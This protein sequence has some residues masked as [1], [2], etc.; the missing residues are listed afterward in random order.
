MKPIAITLGEPAGIGPDIFL[1]WLQ[2]HREARQTPTIVIT[3][4]ALLMDR[5]K[6]LSITIPSELVILHVPLKSH[7]CAGFLNLDNATY[8]LE[9][10]QAAAEGCLDGEFAGMVTGPVH[11]AALNEA[12]IPFTGHTEW[13]AKLMG[14]KHTMM[15]FVT[16]QLKIALHTTHIPLA[17]VASHI[18]SESLGRNIRLLS[19]GLNQYFHLA[20][21]KI[22]VCGLNPHA[23]EQGHCGREEIEIIQPLLRKLKKNGFLLTGPLPADTAFIPSIRDTHDVILA[24]YHDQGLPVIKALGFGQAVNVTLGLPIFRAS[25]DHGTALN[26]A[27]SGH[28]DASSFASAMALAK[29]VLYC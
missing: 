19:H 1:Q 7:C 26:L 5:A 15:L 21:P 23:G 10:L 11:K 9:T 6:Q 28:A 8:V 29:D 25:V 13:L 16:P 17:S 14:I 24:L 27:G 2:S 3:D 20:H 22:A 18:N 4:Q 12:G